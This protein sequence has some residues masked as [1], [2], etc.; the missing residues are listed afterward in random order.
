MGYSDGSGNGQFY[1]PHGVAVGP[2]GT[3]Y[4][5]DTHSQ[6]IQRFTPTGDF[7]SRG[8]SIWQRQR[9]VS[10][11]RG[12]I[13]VGPDDTVYVTDAKMIRIQHFA[14]TGGLLGPGPRP[15]GSGNGQFDNP[16]GVVV[17]PDGTVYVAD[18]FNHRIQRSWPQ[19]ASWPHGTRAVSAMVSTTH[20]V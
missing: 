13:A 18:T 11:I 14:A 4:V 10:P 17:G 8:G 1:E 19:G 7:L 3:V 9:A 15:Q 2:D 16:S 20:G 12:G 5:A 6:R